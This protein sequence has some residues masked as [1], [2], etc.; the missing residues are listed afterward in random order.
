MMLIGNRL[1]EPE[2][3]TSGIDSLELCMNREHY[4]SYTK[5]ISYRYNSKGFRDH[6]WPEDL[7]DVIW[8]VGDSFT[9]GV[10]Q[11]FA[12]TWPQLLEKKIG[13]RC[14]NLGEDGCAN[15][16]MCLRIQEICNLYNPKTIVVMWSYLARRRKNYENVHYDKDSFGDQEDVA[17]FVKNYKIVNQLD[18]KVINLI[19]PN[20]IT[21][22]DIM[23]YVLKKQFK[24]NSHLIHFEQL[25]WARDFHHFDIKTSKNVCDLIAE[26]I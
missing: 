20:A 13:K 22:P 23:D 21:R 10:G 15:D 6:E 7:S 8:C 26:N 16:T 19:I 4:K 9:V 1:G 5:E 12:E 25:D 3:K 14:I 18:T 11:P 17:N 24:K 2:S